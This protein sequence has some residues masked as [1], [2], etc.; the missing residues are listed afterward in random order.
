MLRAKQLLSSGSKRIS[1]VMDD[2]GISNYS[3]FTKHFEHVFEISPKEYLKTLKIRN[4]NN[5]G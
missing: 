5:H 3:L 1:E 4:E 2:V